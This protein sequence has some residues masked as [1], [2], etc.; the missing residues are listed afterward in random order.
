MESWDEALGD[1]DSQGWHQ[2]PGLHV[3]PEFA[4][5]RVCEAIQEPLGDPTDQRGARILQRWKERC[6]MDPNGLT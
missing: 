4:G 5:A 3:H 1:L 6:G 2:L